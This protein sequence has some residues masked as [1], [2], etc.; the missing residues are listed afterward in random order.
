MAAR[1][2]KRRTLSKRSSIAA[3]L[4]GAVTVA[5][6]FGFV[7]LS[8]TPVKYDISVDG[9]APA[10]ITASKDITDTVTTQ[11]LM[12]EAQAQVSPMYSIDSSITKSAKDGI[13]GFFDN[14][15]AAAA[16]VKQE[17]IDSEIRESIYTVPRETLEQRY[18]PADVDWQRYLSDAQ[19]QQLREMTDGGLGD[20]LIYAMAALDE[21]QIPD[22]ESSILVLVDGALSKGIAEEYIDIEKDELRRNAEALAQDQGTANL[23]AY[24]VEK[25]IQ[26][27]MIYDEAATMQ[28]IQNA[29]QS[30]V[31]VTYKQSQTVVVEGEVVTQAQMK[32]LSDLGVIGGEGTDYK[33]YF[34]VLLFVLLLFGSYAVYLHQ[35][36]SETLADTRKLLI[37]AS[38]VVLVTAMGML[39]ARVDNR[40]LPVFFGTMLASVLVSRKSALALGVLLSFVAGA[41]CSWNT[42]LISAVML[43]TVIMTTIGG[44][45]SVLMLY[46]PGHR[47]ALMLSGLA[48]GLASLLITLII[49]MVDSVQFVWSGFWQDGAFALGNG[50][51]AGVLAIGTLPIWEAV[52]RVSTPTKLLELSNPNHPLLKRLT[53]EAPGTYHHSILTANL[54]EAG[55]DAIGANALLCR[56]GAYFH[57][58][59]KLDNP[60]FFKENQKEKNPHDD[61]EP[62]KSAKIITGHLTSGLEYAQKYKLPRD[63]QKVIAQHHGDTF[64]EY[65]LYKARQGCEDVD[66]SKFKYSGSK[67]TTKESAVVMLADNIEA[68]VRS[69]DDPDK[70][71]VKEMI[72]GLVKKRYNEG[73][74]DECPLNRRDLNAIAKAFLTTY[75]GVL[76]ERVKYPGQEL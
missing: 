3:I 39:L 43:K 59:G 19:M 36:E 6:V 26:A 20:E 17:Y 44:S 75:E 41:V 2:L 30:V 72:N 33:L 27:N 67:P 62:E 46:K 69:M 51:L 76:H 70:E 21:T 49:N 22:L 60:M 37:L 12:D 64:V 18:D 31:P 5:V 35:F 4:I 48:A 55:A 66:E 16:Y 15:L 24:P 58:V 8:V 42:G 68:A 63:V 34:G 7:A 14:M 1:K 9:I 52:F 71:Q 10:T 28:A 53:I 29:R 13:T 23:L 61:I 74:L 54:A 50:L 45:V 11:A 56:V 32:V 40:I 65:F 57:D 73:Q 38:I 25:Y 47:T